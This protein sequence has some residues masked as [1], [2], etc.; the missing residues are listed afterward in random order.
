MDDAAQ[1]HGFSGSFV[2]CSIQAAVR[3]PL[4]SQRCRTAGADE[5]Y[6][7]FASAF[8]LAPECRIGVLDSGMHVIVRE[9]KGL[10]YLMRAVYA[11]PRLCHTYYDMVPILPSQSHHKDM[12]PPSK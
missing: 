2:P 3:Q 8:S 7:L 10:T 1:S 11:I 4:G 6:R 12:S 5:R 9:T